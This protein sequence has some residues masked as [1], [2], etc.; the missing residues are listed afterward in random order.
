MHR[1]KLAGRRGENDFLGS[2]GSTGGGGSELLLVG[3]S[4][5]F[6]QVAG[7]LVVVSKGLS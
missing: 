4:G 3:L 5:T 6:W 1:C 7:G 2:T